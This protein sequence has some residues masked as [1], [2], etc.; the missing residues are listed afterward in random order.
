MYASPI[1]LLINLTV[2]SFRQLASVPRCVHIPDLVQSEYL[3][4]YRLQRKRVVW[5]VVMGGFQ[6]YVSTQR[7]VDT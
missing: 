5:A 1:N 6:S 4:G 7:Y 3:G 2:L